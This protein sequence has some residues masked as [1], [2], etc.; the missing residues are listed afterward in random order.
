M[1]AREA[2][3]DV[4]AMDELAQAVKAVLNVLLKISIFGCMVCIGIKYN[5][6]YEANQTAGADA[7]LA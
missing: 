2:K 6:A 3:V 5:L 7:W 1:D 4:H